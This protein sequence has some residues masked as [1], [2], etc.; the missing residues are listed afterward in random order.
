MGDCERA[1]GA[2]GR[3]GGGRGDGFDGE[4]GGEELGGVVF[5]CCC[6]EDCGLG[7]R[8]GGGESGF[9]IRVAAERD[10]FFQ[11]GGCDGGEHGGQG[12]FV[13]EECL[14]CVAGGWIAQLGVEQDLDGHF[15]VCVFVDID[16]AEAVGVAED[17]DPGV[18]LD[19][20]D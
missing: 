6:L 10:A 7:F 4:D 14:D 18:V 15:W 13:D 5:F 11:E 16:A 2:R 1:C 12:G 19:V 8:E 17:R 3:R 9:G 20:S